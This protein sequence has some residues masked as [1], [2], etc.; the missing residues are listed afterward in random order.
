M[1]KFHIFFFD[2][3]TYSY[4]L[5]NFDD[6]LEKN[7]DGLEEL[8]ADVSC[9]DV[10]I[11]GAYGTRV[12]FRV[13]PEWKVDRSGTFRANDCAAAEDPRPDGDRGV[14]LKKF[15]IAIWNIIR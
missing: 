9:D 12:R 1:I 3:Y 8:S 7:V 15:K 4:L 11:P 10:G 14:L 2:M 13:I 6:N 5:E